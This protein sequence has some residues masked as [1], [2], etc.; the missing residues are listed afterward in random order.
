MWSEGGKCFDPILLKSFIH[1]M[2]IYPVGSVVELNDG[3]MA[4]VMDYPDESQKAVPLVMLLVDDGEGG[5]AR[6]EMVHLSDQVMEEGSTRLT[7]IRG[8]QPSRV[9]VQVAQFFLQE[10]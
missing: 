4:L 6:G 10:K 9:G 7:I 1:M 2:G 5:L 8:V 3:H